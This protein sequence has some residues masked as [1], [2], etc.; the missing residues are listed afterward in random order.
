[1]DRAR[2]STAWAS[3]CSRCRGCSDA[4]LRSTTA[5]LIRKKPGEMSHGG[6]GGTQGFW[7]AR[8]A[9]GAARR[10]QAR[11]TA[12]ERMGSSGQ[13]RRERERATGFEPAT[14]SLGS[15]HSTPELRPRGYRY[16]TYTNK[17]AV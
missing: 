2:T 7:P 4:P 15:W 9:A 12:G 3:R 17:P 5:L 6:W 8:G 13:G 10:Q 1:M 16:I 11:A 14:S